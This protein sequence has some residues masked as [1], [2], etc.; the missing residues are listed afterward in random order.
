MNPVKSG[1]SKRNK[2]MQKVT[3]NNINASNGVNTNTHEIIYN[4]IIKYNISVHLC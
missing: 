1:V 4:D 3:P 2:S